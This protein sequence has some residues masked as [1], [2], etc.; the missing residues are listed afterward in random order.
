MIRELSLMRLLF[1][2]RP[3]VEYE[4]VSSILMPFYIY[5]HTVLQ[6]P[7]TQKMN[8]HHCCNLRMP[9]RAD[10]DTLGDLLILR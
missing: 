10:D 1:R 3:P 5:I 9:A 2:R 8:K 4:L 7:L 6:H